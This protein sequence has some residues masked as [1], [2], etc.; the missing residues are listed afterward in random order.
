M[1]RAHL[2]SL[3]TPADQTRAEVRAHVS[4]SKE[5]Q[6]LLKALGARVDVIRGR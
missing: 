6:R 2:G 5:I 1:V 4:N 3:V